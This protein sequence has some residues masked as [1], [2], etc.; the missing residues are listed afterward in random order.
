MGNAWWIQDG[1]VY[2]KYAGVDL[3]PVVMILPANL[4][5]VR[6]L[7]KEPIETREID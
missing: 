1:T 7:L 6:K 4:E 5:I 3:D 2:F